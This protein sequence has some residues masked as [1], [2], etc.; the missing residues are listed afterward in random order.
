MQH[1]SRKTDKRITHS[2]PGNTLNPRA[3]IHHR[4]CIRAGSSGRT[5]T[6]TEKG[7][8]GAVVVVEVIVVVMVVWWWW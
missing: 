6:P 7:E 4:T 8:G 3:A 5:N 1:R 2:I